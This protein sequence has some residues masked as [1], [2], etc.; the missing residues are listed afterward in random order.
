MMRSLWIAA[1]G[2]QS[3]QMN[4]DVCANNLA[5]TNTAGFKR[6]RI[7][8]QDLMYQTIKLPGTV[9]SGGEVIPT[10]MQLGQG[11]RPVAIQKIFVQG[12]Y[13][14]TGNE[15]DLAI[16]GAGFFQVTLPDGEIAYTR[17]GTFKKDSEGRISTSDGY[18]ISP[19]ITVPEDALK[20]SVEADGNVSV[21]EPGQTTPTQ[22]GTIELATFVNPA[23]LIARGKNLFVASDASGEAIIGTAGS[24]GL[25]TIAQGYLEMSNVSVVE[26]MVN[27]IVG[28]RAYE[29]NSKA[30]QAADDMLQ[31]ANNLR[32]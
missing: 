13:Q 15:L 21:L 23:G 27:M 28:Q 2:M 4:I 19:G 17:A 31:I 25:G 30:I 5:N 24:D 22:V 6:S 16:E 9:A 32:R 10:G 11:C 26:E 7:D 3:Q 29:I 18:L 1:S 14:Q 12:D 8:F 20:I